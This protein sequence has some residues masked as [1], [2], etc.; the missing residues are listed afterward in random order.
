MRAKVSPYRWVDLILW[1]T[2]VHSAAVGIGLILLPA[3]AFAYFGFHPYTERFFPI[4]G[5]V[6]HIVMAIAYGLAARSH[7]KHHALIAF[8]ISA[9][10]LATVFLITYYIFVDRV[11]MLLLSSAGDGTLGLFILATYRAA[12]KSPSGSGSPD[13][14]QR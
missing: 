4:Q 12:I 6:F 13:K 10:L 8:I 14:S 5:G 3:S 11:W 1:V 7:G 2:C 9:K